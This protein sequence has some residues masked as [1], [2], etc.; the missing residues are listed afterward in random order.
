MTYIPHSAEA[1][2]Y[3]PF[4]ELEHILG[5]NLTPGLHALALRWCE[6]ACDYQVERLINALAAHDPGLAGLLAHVVVDLESTE[7][8]CA[9]AKA[10]RKV[11]GAA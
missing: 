3:V 9:A 6:R 2:E 10:R 7:G 4:E 11:E 8:L 1:L 5:D